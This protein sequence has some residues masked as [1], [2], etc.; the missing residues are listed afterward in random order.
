MMRVL[1]CFQFLY[2]EK[3]IHQKLGALNQSFK[4]FS[5]EKQPS[6]LYKFL[7]FP[8]LFFLQ[9][10][11]TLFIFYRESNSISEK[12]CNKVNLIKP[13]V[14][15]KHYKTTITHYFASNDSGE[16]CMK[17]S[18]EVHFSQPIRLFR[19]KECLHIVYGLLVP[20][21]EYV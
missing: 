19:Y 10:K 15:Y 21:P 5:A 9:Q 11:S 17:K 1:W 3:K 13:V 18:L 7:S 16:I 12:C 4:L 14:V 2:R 20:I 6:A 8:Q